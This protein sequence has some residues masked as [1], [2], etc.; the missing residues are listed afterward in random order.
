MTLTMNDEVKECRWTQDEDGV[1]QTSCGGSYEIIE[2]T[3]RDN[4]MRFCCFCGK[5]LRYT[6][7]TRLTDD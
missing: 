5:V 6:S 2:G 7:Q 3:P 1:W 4:K